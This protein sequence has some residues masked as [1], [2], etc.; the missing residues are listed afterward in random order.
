MAYPVIEDA[1]HR[2][3][4]QRRAGFGPA[5]GPRLFH[6]ILACKTNV[7]SPAIAAP[8]TRSYASISSTTGEWLAT[9]SPA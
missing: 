3:S 7:L 9:I 5:D 4:D 6:V 8:S 1:L 2:Y